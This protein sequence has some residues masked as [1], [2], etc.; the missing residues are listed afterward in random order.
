LAV[1]GAL[2]SSEVSHGIHYSLDVLLV[3]DFVVSG[4]YF[5]RDMPLRIFRCPAAGPR[6]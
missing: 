6:P 4:F 5:L 1:S 3:G 2:F